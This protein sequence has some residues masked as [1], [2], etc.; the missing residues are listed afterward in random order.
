MRRD[1]PGI[2]ADRSPDPVDRRLGYAV[3]A[4]AVVIGGLAAVFYA[5]HDLT[6]SHYD[7]RA[8]VM[9]ARRLFDSL[10]P[11]WRQIGAVWLPLPHL[12]TAPLVVPDWSYRTGALSTAFSIAVCSGGLA[13][14]AAYLRRTTGSLAA[15][16]AAPAVILLNPNVLYLQS[17]PMTEPLLL[18]LSFLA[19]VAVDAWVARPDDRRRR[20]AGVL[21][22]LL[23]LTRYEGWIVSAV[24]VAISAYGTR[25]SGWRAFGLAPYVLA[26]L[27]GFFWLGWATTGRV[28]MASGFFVPENPSFHR[29]WAAL[30]EVFRATKELGGPMLI[31]AGL[32]GAALC[33]VRA[34][35][36][37]AA[38][39]PLALAAAAALPWFAFFEGHPH[40]V[41]YMVPLVAAAGVFSAWLIGMAPR[42][43]RGVAAALFVGV[44]LYQRPP[45]D[46]HAPMVQEAQW[47]KPWRLERR[48]VTAYLEAHYD[49][50]PIL[51]SMGSLGHYMQ[52]TSTIGLHLANF[53]HEGN[54]DLWVAATTEPSRV[55][56]WVMVEE[57]AEGGDELAGKARRSA[58]YLRGFTRAAAGGGVVLYRHDR[59][60]LP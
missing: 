36:Q 19:L 48:A 31:V 33:L 50:T 44:V 5:W 58:S 38:A 18:A 40:R 27:A 16:I 51:A 15:A 54:G 47:E 2:I 14:L 22:A 34:W 52:E 53:V 32:A 57:R 24:L 60:P 9:V 49:G 43:F 41:R 56:G 59:P 23:S 25:R 21:L 3:F 29:P 1:N 20:W 46:Q 8:H 12:L 11:G 37:P 55:V 35:R 4:G 45:L 6:L 7:A 17:T 30:V 10:T 42:R 26:A 28:F 13:A 39:L